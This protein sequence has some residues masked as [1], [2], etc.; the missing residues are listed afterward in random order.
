[1]PIPKSHPHARKQ[2]VLDGNPMSETTSSTVELPSSRSSSTSIPSPL[3]A[4]T[5]SPVP[6]SPSISTPFSSALDPISEGSPTPL[7]EVGPHNSELGQTHSTPLPRPI[8]SAGAFIHSP[9]PLK[10]GHANSILQDAQ[11]HSLAEIGLG[12][13][14][15]N[16]HAGHARSNSITTIR[17]PPTKP[18]PARGTFSS[19]YSVPNTEV[20]LWS[21]A[22]LLGT[23]ELDE[24][25]GLVSTV[26]ASALRTRLS[27]LSG[28]GVVGGGRMDIGAHVGPGG[29]SAGSRTRRSFISSFLSPPSSSPS[30][31]SS[32]TF[33]LGLGSLSSLWSSPSPSPS[34]L[35]Q[36]GTRSQPS[37]NSPMLAVSAGLPSNA[38]P[39]FE[40]QPSMLAVDLNL[41]P[42]ESRTCE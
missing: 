2:S 37:V 36:D 23:V 4:S 38:L 33:G 20:L 1:M 7:A 8:S 21:Y 24:A 5:T 6:P 42:G 31:P 17:Q 14:S 12:Q 26:E 13:P 3:S 15:S 29:L 10:I 27:S 28:A 35:M 32:S 16:R 40:T 11:Q 34:H 30:S 39:T 22:Q 41:A 9:R 18:A 25:G 19:S